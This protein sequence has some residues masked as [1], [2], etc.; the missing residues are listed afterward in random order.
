MPLGVLVVVLAFTVLHNISTT[1]VSSSCPI[2]ECRCTSSRDILCTDKHLKQVPT[3]K[4]R[5]HVIKGGQQG[6]TVTFKVFD[7]TGNDIV[8]IP[9]YAFRGLRLQSIHIE[10]NPLIGISPNAFSWS[11]CLLLVKKK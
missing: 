8:Q 5:G 3:L 7:L 11:K 4:H 6:S 9:A 1:P 10:N 2:A